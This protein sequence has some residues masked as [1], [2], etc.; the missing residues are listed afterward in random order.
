MR[1]GISDRSLLETIGF[2]VWLRFYRTV[3][4]IC[5]FIKGHGVAGR[6]RLGPGKGMK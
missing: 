5:L 2:K 3:K 1:T 6:G 4:W